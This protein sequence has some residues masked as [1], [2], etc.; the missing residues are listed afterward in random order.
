MIGFSLFKSD[1]LATHTHSPSQRAPRKRCNLPSRRPVKVGMGN[2]RV[3]PLVKWHLNSL[4]QTLPSNLPFGPQ[5]L[6]LAHL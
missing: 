6:H 1:I 4:V 5:V 3:Q 2:D